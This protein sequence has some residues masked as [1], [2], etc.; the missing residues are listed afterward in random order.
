[1][2]KE[3]DIVWCKLEGMY[4]H[5]TYHVKCRVIRYKN[6]YRDMD[7]LCLKNGITYDVNPEH[8]ELAEPKKI[9]WK[10]RLTDGTL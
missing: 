10:E 3:G 2:F 5:T 7:V 8:F 9:N 1:M 4:V 6:D